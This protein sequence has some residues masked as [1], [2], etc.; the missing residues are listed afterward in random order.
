[1]SMNSFQYSPISGGEDDSKQAAEAM[2]QLSG[3]NFYNAQGMFMY[4]WK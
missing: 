1:M 3:S 4:L 2:V